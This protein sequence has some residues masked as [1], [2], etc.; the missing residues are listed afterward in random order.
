MVVP[1]SGSYIL[2]APSSV[3]VPEP[4]GRDVLVDIDVSLMAKQSHLFSAL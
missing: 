4:W 3:K 1:S 2:S